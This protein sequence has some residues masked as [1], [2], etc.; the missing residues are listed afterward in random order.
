M[1]PYGLNQNVEFKKIVGPLLGGLDLRKISKV[2]EINFVEKLSMANR[3]K[4][5]F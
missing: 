1:L 5:I 3:W 4:S 2:E